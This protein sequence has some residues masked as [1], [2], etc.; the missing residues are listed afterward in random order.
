MAVIAPEACS[1]PAWRAG[2]RACRTAQKSGQRARWGVRWPPPSLLAKSRDEPTASGS[3]SVA[4]IRLASFLTGLRRP[5]LPPFYRPYRIRDEEGIRDFTLRSALGLDPGP[6]DPASTTSVYLRWIR[7]RK[8][9]R[10]GTT[11]AHPIRSSN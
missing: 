5:R 9:R 7:A 10:T 6:P 4:H 8:P 3:E 1:E 2:V 11:T